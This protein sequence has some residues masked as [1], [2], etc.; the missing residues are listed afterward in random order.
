M[1]RIAVDEVAMPMFV[2]GPDFTEWCEA[3]QVEILPDHLGRPSVD[4]ATAYRLRAEADEHAERSLRA[5]QEA[6]AAHAAAVAELRKAVAA[7][8]IAETGGEALVS[9]Q[10]SGLLIS[11]AERKAGQ[12]AAGL[13]AAR[14][15]WAAAPFEVRVEVHQLL[16]S[17]GDVT[18]SYDLA[19]VLPRATVDD[20]VARAV[21]RA[22]RAAAI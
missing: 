20:G 15:V 13:D 3:H 2:S 21:A 1:C 17:E 22:N 5:T 10:G 6:R 4:V 14:A 8:F 19:T 11:V 9:Q 7:A 16:V 18:M 12:V